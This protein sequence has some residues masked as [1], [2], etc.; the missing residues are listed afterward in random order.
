MALLQRSPPFHLLT[1]VLCFDSR[2]QKND[3][4]PFIMSFPM[5]PDLLRW[6]QRYMYYGR[7][8]YVSPR[9]SYITFIVYFSHFM[10][11]RLLSTRGFRNYIP[12][13]TYFFVTLQNI[14][15]RIR[16]QGTQHQTTMVILYWTGK[17]RGWNSSFCFCFYIIKNQPVLCQPTII[18][19]A[20]NSY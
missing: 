15:N 11:K 17:R 12:E 6:P 1:T 9:R 14:I 8:L 2:E 13:W 4:I 5:Y 3:S 20:R 10:Q 16:W 19:K 18:A 7:L